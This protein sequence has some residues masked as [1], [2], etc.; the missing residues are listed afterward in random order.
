MRTSALAMVLLIGWGGAWAEAQ[1]ATSERGDLRSAEV[2][3]LQGGTQLAQL[4]SPARDTRGRAEARR[5]YLDLAGYGSAF[6]GRNDFIFGTEQGAVTPSGFPTVKEF[7]H[8]LNGAGA[9]ATGTLGYWLTDR[10]GFQLSLSGA[11][12]D[13]DSTQ[14]CSASSGLL[15][16]IAGQTTANGMIDF[17]CVEATGRLFQT[18]VSYSQRVFD[19][20]LDARFRLR[21]A[22]G[23]RSALEAIAGLTYV[24]LWQQFDQSACCESLAVSLATLKT[25]I[26]VT[27][28]LFGAR[29]GVRGHHEIVSGWKLLGSLLGNVYGRW[30][31]LSATQDATNVCFDSGLCGQTFRLTRSASN[32][33]FVPRLEAGVGLT[34]DLLANWSLGIFYKFDGLWNLSRPDVPRFTGFGPIGAATVADKNQLGLRGSDQ[35]LIHSAG[36]GFTGRF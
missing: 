30:S 20:H 15:P 18:K 5:W 1:L 32:S 3:A 8:D 13:N 2:S 22:A 33:G 26:D 25:G 21:E 11:L 9:G 29:V 24:R 35:G 14:N 19:V 36:V 12:Q 23:G 34:V 17:D 27:D 31:D 10:M 16:V 7:T 6:T 28:N 4:G